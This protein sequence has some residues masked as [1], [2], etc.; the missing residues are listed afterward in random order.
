M[1]LPKH[2]ILI[3]RVE[4]KKVTE[5]GIH[6]PEAFLNKEN[7]ADVIMSGPGIKDE[8][9]VDI[10]AGDQVI[11][12]NY[13]GTTIKLEDEEHLIMGIDE[14]LLVLPKGKEEK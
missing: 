13:A 12:G 3:K 14:V 10:N 9:L 8:I 7:Q 5:G 11:F 1:L 4:A 2:K 6:L